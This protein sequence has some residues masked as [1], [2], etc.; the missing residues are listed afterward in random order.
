M[1]EYDVIVVGAGPCGSSAAKYAADRGAKTILI[2]EHPQIGLPEHCVGLMAGT[3]SRFLEELVKT[4]EK[5]VAVRKVTARRIYSPGGRCAEVNLEKTGAL[6]IERN[7]FDL[8]LAK[9]AANAGA[10]IVVNTAVTGLIKENGVVKGV[11]TNSSTLSQIYGKVVIAA[12]GIR[13]LFKG[14][15]KWEGMSIPDQKV[16][17]GLK[18]HITNVKDTKPGVLEFHLGSF[19]ERGFLTLIDRGDGNCL[20]DI[21][22]ISDFEQIKAGNKFVI[23]QKLKDC[24]VLRVTGFSHPIP[25]GVALQKRVKDGLILSGDGAGFLSIDFAVATGR[26]A[27][28]VAA[29]AVK[30]GDVSEKGLAKCE[31]LYQEVEQRKEWYTSQFHGLEEFFRLPDEEIEKRFRERSPT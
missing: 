20:T 9:Q 3:S 23:S 27:G 30:A 31:K 1:K 2:E 14:I 29:E 6:M 12:D 28:Q 15:A 16:I 19:C 4:M 7:L 13:A 25:M 22:S 18:W 10:E 21:S 5:R 11:N 24:R 26:I 8:E 17:S